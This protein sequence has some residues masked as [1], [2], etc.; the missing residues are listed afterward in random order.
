MHH[1][2]WNLWERPRQA[3]GESLFLRYGAAV[4]L[5]LAA[6]GLLFVRPLFT[7]TPFFVFLGAI[8]LSAVQGGLAPAFLSIALSALLLRLLFVHPI[9]PPHFVGDF[10]GVERMAGF[11]LVSLLLSSFI[12]AI[13]RERNQLRDSEARYRL[14]AETASDAI[15]VI[16]DEGEILYVN[17]EAEKVFGSPARQLV[18]QNLARLL[19]GDGYRAELRGMKQHLDSR[20]KAVAVRLPGLHQNGEPLLVEMTIG[21]SS[22]RG[23]NLF[24][25]IIREITDPNR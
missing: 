1:E 12:A 24:T 18:G 10:G 19:P 14:L 8:V 5:P 13:R 3:M 2:K 25:A 22:H 20:K 15:I 17:P 9:G 11:V 23:R 4:A 6:A 16:D 21:T 7:E